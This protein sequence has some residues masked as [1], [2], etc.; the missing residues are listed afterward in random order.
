MIY[1]TPGAMIHLY[2]ENRHNGLRNYARLYRT[3][4]SPGM[5]NKS[6]GFRTL[7]AR[8]ANIFM[9]APLRD[10][11]RSGVC[12]GDHVASIDQNAGTEPGG[13]DRDARPLACPTKANG[14][15]AARSGAN[16]RPANGRCGTGEAEVT[17]ALRALAASIS[18][19]GDILEQVLKERKGDGE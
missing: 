14:G 11:W 6:N 17:S 9:G 19:H 2:A 8:I 3:G 13:P 15:S 16:N 18:R 10:F 5:V 12:S 4:G 1:V 7:P